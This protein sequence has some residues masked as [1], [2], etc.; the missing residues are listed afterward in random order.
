MAHKSTMVR[1]YADETSFHTD[2]QKLGQE[3]LVRRIES[4][5]IP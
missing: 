2:E 5:A 3:G 1:E 4:L